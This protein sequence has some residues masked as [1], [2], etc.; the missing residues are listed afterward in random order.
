MELVER[1][2]HHLFPLW[3]IRFIG[4][5]DGVDTAER[6]NKKA[7]QITGLIN[8]W[9][10]EISQIISVPFFKKNAGRSIYWLICLLWI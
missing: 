2:L 10:C 4:I 5:V 3:G 1:Y 6:H 7:R 9:Y 8:E